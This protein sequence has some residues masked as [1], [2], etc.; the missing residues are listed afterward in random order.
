MKQ[1]T[2]S[3]NI[4]I[5]LDLGDRRHRFCVLDQKGEVV[6]EGSLNNDRVSLAGLSARYQGGLV[7][8]EAGTHSPWISRYLEGLGFEVIVSNPRKVRAIYQHERKSDQRDALMLARIGRMDRALLYPV[9]HCSE[10][11]QQDL[12]RIKLRDSLVRA[13]VSLI[14]SVRFS[15]KSLGY[16]VR[17]P[18]SERFHKVAMEKLPEAVREMIAPS[19]QA[20]AELS[21]R[22]AVLE[23]EIN[24]LVRT[25]YPQA[26]L[27]QQVP[28]VGALTAL[29]YVLKIEDPTR[30]ENVRDVGAYAGLCPRRDQSGGSDPQL[31]ISKCGDAY[32]RRLLV[33]GAQYILGPFGPKSALREYGLMLAADGTAR[34]KKRAVVA[35]AR[36][37]CVLL[38][39]LWK[40]NS[41]Y[42]PF[43]QSGQTPEDTR[44]GT[45]AMHRLKA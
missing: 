8:M 9:R 25:K 33:S 20:L 7:V 29:Y 32:L 18:S 36:K 11:A 14:N 5:G 45:I 24:E 42:E 41:R 44:S 35:V 17:N 3:D 39:S 15:L 34:A 22:I 16:T 19:V 40:N 10:E 26:L 6:E 12:L 23:R 30:F 13:R 31:R 38:L 43:P 4:T 37:L 1:Q 28:G 27:L 2:K 21:A